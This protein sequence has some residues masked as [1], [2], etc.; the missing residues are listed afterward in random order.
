MS[1]PLPVGTRVRLSDTASPERRAAV[2][3]MLGTIR[4]PGNW[5]HVDWNIPMPAWDGPEWHE[6]EIATDPAPVDVLRARASNLRDQAD[7]LEH[8]ADILDG[9]S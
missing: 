7:A 1:I 9:T 2:G 4:Y 3:D 6:I 5:A 8:A